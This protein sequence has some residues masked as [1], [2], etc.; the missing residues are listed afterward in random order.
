M[1]CYI[2]LTEMHNCRPL[3][4]TS[5]SVK[6]SMSAPTAPRLPRSPANSGPMRSAIVLVV[7]EWKNA[8]NGNIGIHRLVFRQIFSNRQCVFCL[9]WRYGKH[10]I[11]SRQEKKSLSCFVK[12][13]TSAK[14]HTKIGQEWK[15][16]C[17]VIPSNWIA[18]NW[19]Y[20]KSY[21]VNQID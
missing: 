19:N 16:R 11:W 20:C 4:G 8:C 18:L 10:T 21:N 3:I 1:K 5:R 12:N 14:C 17:N 13:L 15:H 6:S 7:K 2:F 9:I